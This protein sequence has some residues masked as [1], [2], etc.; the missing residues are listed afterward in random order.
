MILF[1]IDNT[2]I[3]GERAAK[4]YGQYSLILEKTLGALLGV[5][6]AA[7]K[8]I[9]DD[10][11]AAHGGRGELAFETY[12]FDLTQWHDAL[13]QLTP[14]IYL[15]P[16]I[17]TTQLLQKLR[18]KKYIIGAIT[19]GPELLIEKIFSAAEIDPSLFDFIIGWKRGKPMPKYGSSAIFEQ[20]CDS[21]NIPRSN[22]IMVGDSMGS[23]ILPAQRVGL[24]TFHIGTD[25][26]DITQ[27]HNYL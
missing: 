11:R 15:E 8:I 19:D 2:L 23:D 1:D 27:L 24:R 20:V 21:R 25:I 18:S 7:A 10:H 13:I 9:A 3:F 12:G 26:T 22:A 17:E 16:L 14:E 5:D 6:A 4:L